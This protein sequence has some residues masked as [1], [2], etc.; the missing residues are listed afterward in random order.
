MPRK[1]TLENL[2]AEQAGAEK[3]LA[4][5]QQYNDYVGVLQFEQRIEEISSEIEAI[6][7]A[8]SPFAKVALY[9][10]GRPV[11]GT[12][13]IASEFA[14]RSLENFQALVSKAFAK[15]ELGPLGERGRVP[16]RSNTSLM[17]TSVTHGSFGFVL[18]ELSDQSEMHSTALKSVVSEVDEIL[19]GFGSSDEMDFD[20]VSESIDSR[21][22]ISL[23]DFF[24]EMDS[25]GATVR[26]VEDAR[27]LSLDEE[28][29]RR[30]RLRADAS[31][32]EEDSIEIE[33]LILGF[34]PEHRRFEILDQKLGSIYGSATVIATEQYQRAA[35]VGLAANSLCKGLVQVR[36]V[37]PFNRE[38]KITYRLM[39][40][41]QL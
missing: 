19:S 8:D 12:R 10:S 20:R 40:F 5:A 15:R 9:F 23:R 24:T 26:I 4:L 11:F 13:G 27:E 1:L 32:V 17:V 3:Q 25:S 31:E 16:L 38:P 22:L 35:Q 33:G 14:G 37:R 39:E 7:A 30:A 21:I 2:R 36:T 34:L 28:A 18:E 29:V 6:S 41:T